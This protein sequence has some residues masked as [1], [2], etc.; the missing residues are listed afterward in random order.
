MKIL[1][2]IDDTDNLESIGTGKL[3]ENLGNHL[4]EMNLAIPGFI[5]RHQLHIHESIAYTSHNSS[6]CCQCEVLE[7]KL[8]EVEAVAKKYL[9][10]HA[11][12]GSDPG[13]CIV[14]LD[15]MGPQVQQELI[16]FGLRAKS[17]V[18]QKSDAYQLARAFSGI[19]HLSEHGGTGDGIIGALA[20]CGLRLS[21]HDG[22]LKGK[23]KPEEP[24]AILTVQEF[25]RQYDIAF[26]LGEDFQRIPMEDTMTCKNVIKKILWNHQP[27]VILEPNVEGRAQWRV[28]SKSDLNKKGIGR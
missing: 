2:C 6:M 7:G 13:L 19:I 8:K 10:E 18:L 4:K 28:M 12:E 17:E 21:G 3:L 15:S 16:A 25:C 26:A 1:L 11:A 5:S 9:E 20:G 27:S 24:E 22:R 23:C 14:Q